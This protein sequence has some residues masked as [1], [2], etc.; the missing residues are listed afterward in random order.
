MLIVLRNHVVDKFLLRNYLMF[1]YIAGK[2][3]TFIQRLRNIH[4]T[5]L[6]GERRWVGALFLRDLFT[7]C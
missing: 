5:E 6:L 1:S 4:T 2:L 7:R 3:I